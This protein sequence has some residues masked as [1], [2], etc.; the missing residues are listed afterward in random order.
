MTNPFEP[1]K[2]EIQD[3]AR[4]VG[5]QIT[6]LRQTSVERQMPLSIHWTAGDM[7]RAV[8]VFLPPGTQTTAVFV[9]T[10]FMDKNGKTLQRYEKITRK[11]GP[12]AP[13][14]QFLEEAGHLAESFS[15][16][17]LTTPKRIPFRFRLRAFV[18]SPMVHIRPV[19]LSVKL[20]FLHWKEARYQKA[21]SVLRKRNIYFKL[22][23][24]QTEFHWEFTDREAF[25]A[26][27]LRIVINQQDKTQTIPVIT[28]GVIAEGWKPLGKEKDAARSR[29]YFG[30]VSSKK[31][32]VSNR[33]QVEIHLT[34]PNDVAG[35]GPDCKG[36]LKAG[37]YLAKTA[38]TI[39]ETNGTAFTGDRNCAPMWDLQITDNKGW[40]A[41]RK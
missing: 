9:A 14:G 13:F 11:F 40:M 26:G 19:L 17:S 34:L 12:D 24:R 33:D 37:S 35:I 3:F 39:Y 32:L 41:D 20:A 16:D 38:F 29:I 5:G 23:L 21:I 15:K 2:N 25:L 10:A 36:I 18:H 8:T 31:F 1:F 30:F 28:R 27:E 22:P 4:N 6:G 7:S